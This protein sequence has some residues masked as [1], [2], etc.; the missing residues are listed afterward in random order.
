MP[1]QTAPQKNLLHNIE[2]ALSVALHDV[3]REQVESFNGL[4]KSKHLQTYV[5]VGA[6][7]LNMTEEL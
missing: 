4:S 7:Q 3:A 2:S 1:L 5:F 6:Q